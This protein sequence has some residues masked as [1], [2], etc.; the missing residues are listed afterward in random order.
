MKQ[1]NE[2]NQ[3]LDS[4]ILCGENMARICK[5]LKEILPE[6]A[7][8][9]PQKT[10]PSP[11]IKADTAPAKLPEKADT[12]AAKTYTFADV[13]KAFSAKSHEGYTHQVKELISKFGAE[14]LSD[15]KEADYTALMAALEVIG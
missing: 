13:R 1:M 12:P 2:I 10:K 8:A 6:F 5:L 9:I 4:I 14:K 3:L 7:D 11:V 15:V